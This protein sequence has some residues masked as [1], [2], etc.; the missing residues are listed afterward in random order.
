MKTTKLNFPVMSSWMENN[1]RR[2]DCNPYL[3]G[4]FEAK[5]I[6]EKLPGKKQPLHEVTKGGMEGI[7][8]GPRFSRNYVEDPEYGVPF[9]G[10]I[11]IL[12]ADLSN[13][14]LLSKKQVASHPELLI[15]EGW[16]LI[17]C[18]G[19]IGRMV[20][21][22]SEMMGMAGSQHFMRV[23]AN[24]DKIL[25]GYLYAYLSSSFGVPIVI[26]GT[27]GSII[28]SIEPQH[29]ADLPVPR[30]GK[31]IEDKAHKNIEESARLRSEYQIQIK[32]ATHRLFSAVGLKDITAVDWHKM[33][34]DLGFSH[35]LES[36][37]SLRA[38]N[39]NPRFKKLCENIKST[40]YK[41]LGEICVPGTLQRGGRYKR[42]D[43][44]PEFGCQLIGQ[45]QLFWLR[46]EGRWVVKSALG[47]DVFVQP[48]TILI[49]ATGTLGE[50]ELYCR[51]EIIWGSAV[52]M[53]YSELFVRVVA[54]EAIMPRG[55]LFA[56]MRSETAFRMLRSIAFG[57]KLQYLHPDFIPNLPIPYPAQEIQ[58]KIHELV[59]DAYEKR[60]LSN[61]LEDEAVAIVEQA[62]SL[63]GA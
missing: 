46:P 63:G 13:L 50:S 58:Q 51:S 6:L 44:D 40:K 37:V 43:A 34:T 11:D 23:I 7:F 10:S 22:R 52:S 53:A 31:Y 19:T 32:K 1:G 30:L 20:Y 2:L 29:I 60:H 5:V 55:C 35:N 9:L 3:S 42:I 57:S 15:D 28:Q 4:A 39:F 25:P 48:G 41:E 24:P 27:Y 47:D 12:A 21:S 18:S 36:H 16:T 14:T 62:I 59:V 17:T 45:R 8:N 54:D 33:G 49:A 56:F 38:A 61:I 26:S